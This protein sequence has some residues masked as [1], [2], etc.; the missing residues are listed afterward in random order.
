MRVTGTRDLNAIKTKAK[1][2]VDMQAENQRRQFI[3]SGS[4]Q[5][6]V[7]QEK[8]REA[9]DHL[10]GGTGPWLLLE[11]SIGI[12][13]TTITEIAELV[14]STAQQWKAAAATIEA[15]RLSRKK[16]IDA[17]VTPAEIAAI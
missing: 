15:N 4:G 10:N 7:Y 16:A 8:L 3:T 13:G 11:A 14:A 1:T 5:A 9:E 6:M 17:A 12:E 2:V